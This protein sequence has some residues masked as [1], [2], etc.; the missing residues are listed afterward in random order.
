MELTRQNAPKFMSMVPRIGVESARAITVKDQYKRLR[1]F[2]IDKGA[3]C[4]DQKG[5][6][7]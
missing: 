5:P 3:T 6:R 2:F 7:P 4:I 1:P